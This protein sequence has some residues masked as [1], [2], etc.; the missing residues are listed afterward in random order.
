M[1]QHSSLSYWDKKTLFSNIDYIIIGSG[2]VGLNSA[3]ELRR[4]EPD[5]KIVILERGSWPQGASTKN[6]GFACF[7]SVSELLKDLNEQSPEAVFQLVEK[8]LYGIQRLRKLLGDEYLEYQNLGGYEVFLKK[9]E[10]LYQSCLSNIDELNR[11]LF[12]FF[13]KP[14]F[15]IV[16]NTFGFRKVYPKVIFNAFEGQL[17]TGKMMS[18][19]LY[20]AHSANI[21]ILNNCTV[22]AY[23]DNGNSVL[24]ETNLGDFMTK[25]LVIATNGFAKHLGIKGCTPAR[26]QV[27]ITKPIENLQIKGA[28][29][30]DQ[31]YYYFRN[32]ENRILFGGGRNLNFE[33]EETTDFGETSVVQNKLENYLKSIILP[34]ISFEIDQRWS[35]IMGIGDNKHPIIKQ[36]SNRVYCGI[37]LG[38]MGVAIGHVVGR[39]LAILAAT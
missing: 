18:G 8:R 33:E 3:L 34:D 28:F 2:I 11:L 35:G 5:A 22:S 23:N 32:V 36:L 21:T 25:K 24:L 30:I 17:D 7:G 12:P 1:K 15:E 37:K 38:G 16:N 10:A 9:D 4:I 14:V 20:K 27:L 29:H 31:G 26:A 6:A 13:N 19:L 39:D